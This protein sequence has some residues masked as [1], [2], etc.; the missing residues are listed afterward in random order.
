MTRIEP[1]SFLISSYMPDSASYGADSNAESITRTSL[2]RSDAWSE[3]N[4]AMP[5]SS[6]PAELMSTDAVPQNGSTYL[7]QDSD[8]LDTSGSSCGMKF[9]LHPG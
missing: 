2:E 4:L 9:A 6:P 8:V 7:E 5:K 1:N 3:S